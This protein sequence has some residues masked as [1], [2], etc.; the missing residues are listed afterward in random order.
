MHV[1]N[2]DFEV[3]DEEL[4]HHVERAGYQVREVCVDRRSGGK[5]EGRSNGHALVTLKSA[6]SACHLAEHG[7][8][9]LRGRAPSLQLDSVG[10]IARQ[11]ARADV[12]GRLLCRGCGTAVVALMDTYL[13]EGTRPPG[14][15]YAPH[16]NNAYYC[17][18]SE[19]NV[20]ACRF[21][22]HPDQADLPFK[23][24]KVSCDTCNLDIGN[25]QDA[26]STGLDDWI[27]MLGP[28]V[29]SFKCKN[30]VLQLVDCSEQ[31]VDVKKWSVLYAVMGIGDSRL[32]TLTLRTL[33]PKLRCNYSKFSKTQNSGK[34]IRI[35]AS[36]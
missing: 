16:T 1:R 15:G 17:I 30:V 33:A 35:I 27:S 25:V 2:L 31:V 20:R 4:C 36:Q 23:L 24:K 28:G 9:A 32:S 22:E 8:R 21:Q 10:G 34:D 11:S 19:G 13:V 12:E 5:G 29:M 14:P 18:C 6:E 3:G 26:A 7:L